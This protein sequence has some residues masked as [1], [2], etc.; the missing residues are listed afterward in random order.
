MISPDSAQPLPQT[1][2]LGSKMS[3]VSP[4]Q[5][6]PRFF[7]HTAPI[8]PSFITKQDSQ[9]EQKTE[10]QSWWAQKFEKFLSFAPQT[11]S[12]VY[13]PGLGESSNMDHLPKMSYNKCIQMRLPIEM[14]KQIQ[15]TATA[16][17]HPEMK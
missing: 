17:A 10:K 2:S 15:E 6:V 5:E 4:L 7:S 12:V 14:C 3:Q 13:T 16:P 9:K 11:T 8:L 1:Y